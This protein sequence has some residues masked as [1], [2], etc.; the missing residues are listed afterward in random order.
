MIFNVKKSNFIIYISCLFFGVVLIVR[1]IISFCCNK[2]LIFDELLLSIGCSTIPTVVTA[3]L[4]DRASEKRNAAKILELR[5]HFLWGMPQG[6]M[7]IMKTII[8]SYTCKATNN[9][10]HE[11][12]KQSILIMKNK[13]F[14]DY[15]FQLETEE[16]KWL[17]GDSRLGYGLSLCLRDCKAII[18]HDHSLEM[19]GVFSK[20]ELITV[21][22][23]Y[24]EC[25]RIQKVWRLCEM[26]EYI[27]CFVD[28][29]IEKIPEIKIKANRIAIIKNG[30]VDNWI[31]ISK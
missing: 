20:D 30:L 28:A 19:N 25:E 16:R 5:D 23:L 26:A 17:L 11:C 1:G 10:F 2:D 6:L 7:W 12:F 4:I 8:E 9:T 29:V 3:F 22:F 18:D 27:E 21:A 31:D 13:Q 15:D 24:E 14:S